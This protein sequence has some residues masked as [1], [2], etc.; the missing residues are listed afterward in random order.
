[1]SQP[2]A[3]PSCNQPS[4]VLCYCCDKN[5]CLDHLS[6]HTTLI[7]YQ[8]QS[9]PEQ[10]NLLNEQLKRLDK[11]KLVDDGRQKLDKW[12]D[13][14]LKKIHRFHEQKCDELE[15]YFIL[16]IRQK[17]YET[18]QLY[19]KL[20]DYN[21]KSDLTHDDY[22]KE[23]KIIIFDTKQKFDSIEQK[24][25]PISI[26]SLSI[27]N[28]LIHIGESKTEEFDLT[29]LSSPPYQ[30][31]S[32]SNKFGSALTSNDRY[33]LIDQNPIL[34][35]YDS[36]L[37]IVQESSW[38]NSLIYD[39]C[40]SSI[41]SCFIIITEKSKAFLINENNLSIHNIQS[42]QNQLWISCTCSNSLLYLASLSNGIVEFSLL[43]SISY[44][45]RWD[46]PMTCQN[47]ESIK[48]IACNDITLALLI[49]PYSN[50][51]IYIILRSLTSF[52][53][54]FT[55]HLDI[56][57]PLYQLP[58]R[59]CPLK[60]NEWLVIDANTSHIFHINKYGKVKRTLTYDRPP[61]NAV[62]FNSTKLVIRTEDSINFH[63]LFS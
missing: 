47:N 51:M 23:L 5:L 38:K 31:F 57:H 12:R 42:M 60:N 32:C 36:D 16:N 34:S 14:S 50:K 3:M 53:E 7:D 55:V 37:R 39:M 40:W 62:L 13:E 21:Q 44:I 61:Y 1:M 54:L 33:L 29:I 25:I 48:D 19:K 17:Q 8:S 46:P 49:S 41:L 30:T 15:R 58:T 2:C 22:S 26:H 43:P 28:N 6:N 45:K 56:Q 35:L 59:C 63:Q 52:V 10:V 4:R 20:T 11:D 24:G 9:L 18:D 27:G